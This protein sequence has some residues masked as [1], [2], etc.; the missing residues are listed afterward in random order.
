MLLRKTGSRPVQRG[1]ADGEVP[2]E[3]AKRAKTLVRLLRQGVIVMIWVMAL[4]V[5]LREPGVEIAP[6][7][8]SAGILGLAVAAARRTWCA[9]F[10]ASCTCSRTVPSTR[11][12][13]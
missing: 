3:A 10:R 6:I 5:I 2:A 11:W 12:P 1:Q 9:I 4:L 13:M 8:A 7:L